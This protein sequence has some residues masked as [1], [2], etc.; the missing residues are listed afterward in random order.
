VRGH[1]QAVGKHEAAHRV[2]R[3]AHRGKNTRQRAESSEAAG[4]HEVACRVAHRRAHRGENT[5]QRAESGEAAGKHE[6]LGAQ[7][8]ARVSTKSRAISFLV[9]ALSCRF[10][11]GRASV[12]SP[13]LVVGFPFVGHVLLRF[14]FWPYVMLWQR[15]GEMCFVGLRVDVRRKCVCRRRLVFCCFL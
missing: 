6:R 12:L 7:S 3:R 15:G 14:F 4:K 1:G 9:A 11:E 2:A 5:R 10:L 8:R 13:V